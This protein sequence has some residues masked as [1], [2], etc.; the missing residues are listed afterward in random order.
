P[1]QSPGLIALAGIESEL[2]ELLGGR[3]VDL[4]S[5]QDLS[6]HLRDE[7]VRTAQLQYAADATRLRHMVP[8]ANERCSPPR[9][10]L[11]LRGGAVR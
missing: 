8:V 10:K 3:R 1:N 5:P 9:G 11:F 7:V 6:R 2:C 4:R